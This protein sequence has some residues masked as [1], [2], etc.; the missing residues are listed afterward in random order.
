MSKSL[1]LENRILR[2]KGEA[3]S[4]YVEDGGAENI[5]VVFVHSFAG[6][7]EHWKNQLEHLRER[8]R[9]IAFDWRGHG[10]SDKPSNDDYSV[11]SIANDIA[12]VVDTLDLE[13]FVL[14]GHS[15]GGS[16]AIAYANNHVSRVAGLLVAA[17]PGRSP[18]DIAK[19]VMNSLR[20]SAYQKV[21]DDYM[22]QL[23]ADAHAVVQQLVNNGVKKNSREANIEMIKALFEFDPV[24][25]LKKFPGPK[26]I[27]SVAREDQQPNS[28]HNQLPEVSTTVIEGTS[29]WLHL[30][31]PDRFNSIIDTFLTTIDDK[32][33]K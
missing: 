32:E 6:S 23:L 20:S 1:T 4:L 24:D 29:H 28:L 15:M 8:H 31:Q 13:R 21:M 26:L 19:S 12:A 14:I 25:K 27:V 16:A 9:A 3:G 17:T 18:D 7:I 30:D 10:K 2:A 22:S 33:L 5:P 11:E